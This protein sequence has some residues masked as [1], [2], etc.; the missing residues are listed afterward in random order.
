MALGLDGTAYLGLIDSRAREPRDLRRPAPSGRG[1]KS[2]S[3]DSEPR[4]M[5]AIRIV[6]TPGRRGRL[7]AS[8]ARQLYRAQLQ[9]SASGARP[10]VGL[11]IWGTRAGGRAVARGLMIMMIESDW[12]RSVLGADLAD[13]RRKSS[14]ENRAA[15]LKY[16]PNRIIT[17]RPSCGRL[18]RA[19][20]SA[21]ELSGESN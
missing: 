8:G 10:L 14:G 20:L 6:L 2:E 15:H 13:G 12:R 9:M 4:L 3:P 5:S 21:G 11:L 1:Q 16:L 17:G 19:A 7:I 18:F